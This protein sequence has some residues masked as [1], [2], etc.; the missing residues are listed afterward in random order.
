MKYVA[1]K[2][3]DVIGKPIL[4]IDALSKVTGDAKFTE[5]LKFP[6]ILY[7]KI[8]R[9]PYAHARIL[10]IDKSEAEKLAGV[11]AVVCGD[12]FPLIRFGP[13]L[14]DQTLFAREKVRYVGEEVAAVA[15]DTPK[16]AEEALELIQVDYEELPTVF[17]P[18]EAMKDDAVIIHEKLTEYKSL[19]PMEARGNILSHVSFYRG[20]AEKSFAES[21]IVIEETFQT[22]VQYQAYLENHQSISLVDASGKLVVYAPTQAV[23][24]P[25]VHLHRMLQIPMSRIRVVSPEVGGGFGGKL[26]IVT[27]HF[28]SVLAI[29]TKRPV[30]VVLSRA[31]DMQTARL[32]PPVRTTIKIGFKK[33]GTLHGFKAN[34]VVDSG[35]YADDGPGVTDYAA[36]R[37]RGPYVCPNIRIDAYNV[38]TNKFIFGAMR[39][40]GNPEVSFAR[41]QMFDIAAEKL[42]MSP[43]DIRAKNFVKPGDTLVTGQIITS[44]G[45]AECLEKVRKSHKLDEPIRGKNRGRGVAVLEHT[46]GLLASSVFLKVNE[47]GSVHLMS[48]ASSI[49]GGQATVLAQIVA[50]ALGIEVEQI[51]VSLSDTEAVPYD[52][53]VR[54]SRTTYNVG[55]AVLI[56]IEDVK[57]QL[58]E[59]AARNL[60]V[61]IGQLDAKNGKVMV[62]GKPDQS[63]TIA[64]IS[65]ARLYYEG[66][67]FVPREVSIRLSR[68]VTPT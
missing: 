66:G 33:D 62:K 55:N 65:F 12:D 52:Y 1:K 24:D 68:S 41:E 44:T 13:W 46:T 56:A 64:E 49:G 40:Y 3:Y 14:M 23:F 54:A 7:G 25:A 35:A 45:V 6:G 59:V 18:I 19:Y 21:D 67:P 17:D 11:H 26:N 30:K 29:K 37:V 4:R 8:L 61:S 50:E 31:E 51:H 42:G 57:R 39:G 38:Y 58:F 32:R 47:D 43:A 48:G 15:A 10:K 2:K 34:I 28:S 53:G 5:D 16:I 63:M 22:S 20:D 9:S 27:E 60:G 36:I